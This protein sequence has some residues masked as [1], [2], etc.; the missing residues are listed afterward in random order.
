MITRFSP[1]RIRK[2]E[3]IIDELLII[4]NKNGFYAYDKILLNL[5]E[6]I[7]SMTVQE[8]ISIFNTNALFGGAGALWEI[9]IEDTDDRIIFIKLFT[10]LITQFKDGGIQNKRIDEVKNILNL[11]SKS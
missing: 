3:R 2:I 4:L 1:E 11:I 7:K 8:L 10:D 6:C 9:Y 5:K